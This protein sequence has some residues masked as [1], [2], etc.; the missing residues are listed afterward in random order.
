MRT[1]A[2]VEHLATPA[3][4][5]RP[6]TPIPTQRPATPAPTPYPTA[7]AFTPRPATPVPTPYPTTPAPTLHPATPVPTPYPAT[8][9][10]TQRPA[11]PAPTQR[12]TPPVP[13]TTPAPTRLA[14]VLAA[15]HC[16]VVNGL[17]RVVVL[18]QHGFCSCTGS[19]FLCRQAETPLYTIWNPQHAHMTGVGPVSDALLPDFCYIVQT[20]DTIWQRFRGTTILQE[21]AVWV[22]L[23][24]LV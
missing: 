9:A 3:P 14:Y 10:P 13:P 4:T 8:P 19:L 5:Q 16:S 17:F 7:P 15:L 23:H 12:P 11:T 21:E 6:A 22:V 2:P 20:N 24:G 1:A 18:T